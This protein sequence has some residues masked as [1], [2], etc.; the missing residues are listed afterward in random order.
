MTDL[1]LAKPAPMRSA[2]PFPLVRCAACG[3]A[4]EDL[5][6]LVES[7][8]RPEGCPH[9]EG[10]PGAGATTLRAAQARAAFPLGPGV[11]APAA[12]GG[13]VM[14]GPGVFLSPELAE[15]AAAALSC[16]ARY[17]R[18]QRAHSR[19]RADPGPVMACVA[20]IEAGGAAPPAVL[21]GVRAGEVARLWKGG[22]SLGQVI[23]ELSAR[24]VDEASVRAALK[25]LGVLQ[26]AEE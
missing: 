13:M 20:E 5:E 11:I 7:C 17:A 9:L 19:R 12:V 16:S 26:E 2:A 3:R 22:Q 25:G 1:F 23:D 4:A 15:A 14:V 21:P 18:A 8:T 10:A 24:G 6:Q